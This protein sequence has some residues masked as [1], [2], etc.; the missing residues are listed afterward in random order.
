MK[1]HYGIVDP[2]LSYS[3]RDAADTPS[4]DP[5]GVGAGSYAAEGC[6][7]TGGS[8]REAMKAQPGHYLPSD[9]NF[10]DPSPDVLASAQW[11]ATNEP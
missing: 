11:T 5:V 6:H 3:N 8:P 7:G 1:H 4:A 2:A 9:K 10:I